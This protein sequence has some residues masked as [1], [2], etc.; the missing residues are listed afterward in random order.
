MIDRM[1]ALM[2]QKVLTF[3]RSSSFHFEHL[4]QFQR[5]Q[6][7]VRQ[8]KRNSDRGYARRGKPLV[9]Q[10]AVR[11]ERKAARGELLVEL[12][13]PA[14]E[15]AP[16]NAGIQIADPP[17]EQLIVFESRPGRFRSSRCKLF[18]LHGFHRNAGPDHYPSFSQELND[19]V[20]HASPDHLNGTVCSA[21][22]FWPPLVCAK[23]VHVRAWFARLP[24]FQPAWYERVVNERPFQFKWDEAKAD[25]NVRKHGVTFEMATTVFFDPRLLT[26]ADLEHSKTEERWFSVGLARNGILVAVVYLWSDADLAAI[27]IRLISA[28]RATQAESGQYQEGL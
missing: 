17:F 3:L 27:A 11:M 5:F 8:I 22:S 18:L 19:V 13:D 15:F 10:I 28:R 4:V 1:A 21:F 6:A 14:L 12:R 24:A 25:A 16:R 9:A 2:P 7:R 26:V 20:N 23:R